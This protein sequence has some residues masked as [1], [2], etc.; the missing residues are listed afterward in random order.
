MSKFIGMIHIGFKYQWNMILFNVGDSIITIFQ[1]MF[2]GIPRYSNVENSTA[3]ISSTPGMPGGFLGRGVAILMLLEVIIAEVASQ[4]DV[5]STLS[6]FE[7]EMFTTCRAMDWLK[8][9]S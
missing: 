3:S 2:N 5:E 6:R 4:L 9:K 7:S 8:G 1:D